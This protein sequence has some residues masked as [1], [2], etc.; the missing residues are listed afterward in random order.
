LKN[1][2]EQIIRRGGPKLILSYGD[3]FWMPFSQ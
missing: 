2:R 1:R 3:R